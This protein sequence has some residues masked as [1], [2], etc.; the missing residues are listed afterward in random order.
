MLNCTVI[1]S[2]KLPFRCSMPSWTS[3]T[4]RLPSW[5]RSWKSSWILKTRTRRVSLFW[6]LW[7]VVGCLPEKLFCKWSPSTC[8]PLSLPRSTV[9]SCSMRDL[10]MMR[11]P[12]VW[13]CFIFILLM[14][15]G[16]RKMPD[17]GICCVL[18]IVL[19][20]FFSF[21]FLIDHFRYQ[22]LWPEGALDDVHLQDGPHLWQGSLLCIRSCVLWECL[23]WLEST[24]Y[25]TKLCPWK[26]GGPL[27]ETHSEVCFVLE[28]YKR[29]MYHSYWP[30]LNCLLSSLTCVVL[31]QDHFDDGT[32]RWAHWGCAMR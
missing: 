19:M 13:M 4:R 8:L 29:E 18:G 32:L 17:M 10:E 25:G 2:D 31:Y 22:E 3:S 6:R 28:C 9:V 23:H 26:E 7:C 11:L 20:V 1:K 12:W 24:H 30:H 27:C 21:L 5:S 14:Q 16:K 15:T